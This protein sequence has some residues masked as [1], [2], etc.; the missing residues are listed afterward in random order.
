MHISIIYFPQVKFC[1]LASHTA[2]LFT[3][4]K[5]HRDT[6]YGSDIWSWKK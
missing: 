6:C 2:Y 3:C 5:L 1:L 4:S